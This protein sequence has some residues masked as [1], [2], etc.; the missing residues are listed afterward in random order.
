MCKPS[1]NKSAYLYLLYM[2][3]T[4]MCDFSRFCYKLWQPKAKFE[5]F[6]LFLVQQYFDYIIPHCGLDLQDSNPIFFHNTQSHDDAPPYYIWLQKVKWFRRDLVDKLRCT[7]LNGSEDIYWTKPR[8]ED[9]V[10]PV[11]PPTS[12]QGIYPSWKFNLTTLPLYV[13]NVSKLNNT[14]TKIVSSTRGHQAKCIEISSIRFLRNGQHTTS[15]P[16][17]AE[18][19]LITTK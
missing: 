16:Q 2:C 15:L 3:N 19:R 17:T 11:Y 10:I 12:L 4:S 1:K 6:N 5:I 7:V 9:T 18:Q 13:L 14:A 8:H